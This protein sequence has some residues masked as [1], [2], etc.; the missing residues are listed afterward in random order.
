MRAAENLDTLCGSD[1][2][3]IRLIDRISSVECFEEIGEDILPA[4]AMAIDAHGAL[5]RHVLGI[6]PSEVVLWRGAGHDLPR[7]S[8]THLQDH[9]VELEPLARLA[10]A[11]PGSRDVFRPRE[12]F[13]HSE[14]DRNRNFRQFLDA[15]SIHDVVCARVEHDQGDRF[16]FGFHRPA[17]VKSFSKLELFRLS[18][19]LAPL[20]STLSRLRFKEQLDDL[21]TKRCTATGPLVLM[22]LDETLQ[23]IYV[24]AKGRSV[25]S[26][27]NRSPRNQRQLCE[28]EDTHHLGTDEHSRLFSFEDGT[29]L[30]RRTA[31]QQRAHFVIY[32]GG[33]SDTSRLTN[34]TKREHDIVDDLCRG[35]SNK[36]IARHRSI[37]V[38]TVQNHLRAIFGK[39]GHTSRT[40]LILALRSADPRTHVRGNSAGEMDE[41]ATSSTWVHPPQPPAV[42]PVPPTLRK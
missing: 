24:H 21:V 7:D 6:K 23:P 25:L 41:R 26:W 16:F 10:P 27:L 22:V 34:L 29:F 35:L 17:S 39:L 1:I 4:L 31:H 40:K 2:S 12:M 5:F 30:V 9:F 19:L 18:L 8:L 3:L 15:L 11:I 13:D 14:L 42:S 38:N 20:Q 37:S 36:E 33:E 32:D 28:V